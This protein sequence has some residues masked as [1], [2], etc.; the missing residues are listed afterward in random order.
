MRPEKV[1]A[2]YLVDDALIRK[3]RKRLL[4]IFDDRLVLNDFTLTGLSIATE[5]NVR[6]QDLVEAY[7]TVL[8]RVGNVKGFTLNPIALLAALPPIFTGKATAM[9]QT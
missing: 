8:R 2:S 9:I 5:L 4:K 6:E 1:T 3:L 7:M